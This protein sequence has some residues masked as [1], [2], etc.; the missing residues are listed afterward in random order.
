MRS[1][2]EGEASE[3]SRLR[4][5]NPSTLPTARM[6]IVMVASYATPMGAMSPGR[7]WRGTVSVRSPKSTA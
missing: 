2:P 7:T 6:L 3:C 1:L 4:R 5:C